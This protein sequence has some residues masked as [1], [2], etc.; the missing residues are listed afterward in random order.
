MIRLKSLNIYPYSTYFLQH[1]QLFYSTLLIKKG[2]DLDS[3]QIINPNRYP[4]CKYETQSF[5]M[6]ERH[7]YESIQKLDYQGNN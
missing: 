3:T 6:N 4:I 1:F 5:G 7:C 2:P